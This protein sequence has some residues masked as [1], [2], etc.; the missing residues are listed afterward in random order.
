MSSVATEPAEPGMAERPHPGQRHDSEPRPDRIPSGGEGHPRSRRIPFAKLVTYYTVTAVGFGLLIALVPDARRALVS[1]L[2][3][4]SWLAGTAPAQGTVPAEIVFGTESVATH[5][6]HRTSILLLVLLSTLVP[7]VPVTWVYMLT[8]R[9]RF[10]RSLVQSMFL[11]PI[12]V[13]G[14][15]LVIR[16][17]I[18]VAFGLVGIVAAVRF[19]NTLKDPKDAAY[20]FLALGIGLAAGVQAVDVAL[21][22][23]L[24]FNL[25]VLTLWKFNI[26][27]I[28]RGRYGR[29]G[30]FAT[31]DEH[32]WIGQEFEAR[33]EMREKLKKEAREMKS[34]GILLVH[35]P[36][37]RAARRV[38]EEC[39][40]EEARD[41]ELVDIPA[42]PGTFSTLEYLVRLRRRTPPAELLGELDD[43]SVEE[44]ASAEYIP[45]RRQR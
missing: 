2:P 19:R 44:I 18:A 37:A 32:L 26:G 20:I 1:P 45:F 40:A 8:R 12:V 7:V 43:R 24:I 6:L 21:V 25:V 28:Y 5:L 15:L 33:K 13:A 29:T 38:V 17:S 34:D 4:S 36:D 42:G 10:D 31:G 30:I 14:I 35:S 22:M 23:S 41:W 9:L 16:N 27:S 11:L 39:L 3:F